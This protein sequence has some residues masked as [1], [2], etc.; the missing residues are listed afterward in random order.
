M[1]EYCQGSYAIFTYLDSAATRLATDPVWHSALYVY[2]PEV[3]D[4]VP[5]HPESNIPV[6]MQEG[7]RKVCSQKASDETLKIIEEAIYADITCEHF[8]EALAK[9]KT[10]SAPGP[11]RVTANMFKAWPRSAKILVY[12]YMTN[13]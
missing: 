1:N 12:K 10:G 4:G 3:H 2:V 9:L 11:S 5:L 7:L 13:I 6:Y 8:D